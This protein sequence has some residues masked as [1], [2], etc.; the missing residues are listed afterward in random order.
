MQQGDLVRIY[1]STWDYNKNSAVR[2]EDEPVVLGQLD[3][4]YSDLQFEPG[5]LGVIVDVKTDPRFS[6]TIPVVVVLI[7]G[8]I[9]WCF[10]DECE[11]VVETR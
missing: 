6:A 8:K 10:T 11:V 4:S 2:D 3:G 5:S 1:G 7:Q 9:G